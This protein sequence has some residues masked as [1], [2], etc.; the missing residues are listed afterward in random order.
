MFG[1]KNNLKKVPKEELVKRE[2]VLEAERVYRKGLATVKD[3]IA[4][5]AMKVTPSFV[6]VGDRYARTLFIYTY[7][8]FLQTS[9]FSP[10]VN[11]NHSMD[12][13]MF[14]YAVDT[15]LLLKKLRNKVGQ[16]QTSIMMNEEKGAVRDPVLDTA[17]HDVE[18]LRD[19]LQQG[20]EKLFRF[21]LYITVYGTTKKELDETTE[22]MESVL[23]TKLVYSKHAMMQMEEGFNSTLPLGN[24]GLNVETNLNTAPLSTTFPFVSNELTSNEG[25]LYGINR[26]NNSLILF[27]RFSMENANA[28]VFA[29]SGAGKSY[30][31]KLEILRSLMMG[32]NVIVI[33]PENEY[34]YLSDAVGGSYL[35]ISLNADNRINPFDLPTSKG[36]ETT[37]DVL[38]SATVAIIGLMNLMLGEL[39]P[40]EDSIMDTAITQTYAKKDI[41]SESDLSKVSVPTM[42]DLEEVLDSMEGGENLALRLQKYTQGTFAGVFNQESNIN[43]ENQFVVFSIRDLE[44][45]LRPIGMYVVLNYIWNVVRS[46]L[47]RRILVV[48]EAWWMMQYEDS[49][50][51]LFGLAKRA[52]KYYLGVT[53][54]SQDVAD[55]LHS[56]YGKAIVTNSSIQ[57]LLKQSPAAIDLIADTFHLTD[58]EKYLLL[59]SDVGEG[60][61]FAGLKHVAIKIVASYTEDQVITSDPRQL[62]EIEQAKKDFAESQEED[63]KS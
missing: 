42:Q 35:D 29:K 62:L 52:R 19:K 43:M 25:I 47:K 16:I 50:K 49:A 10:I 22:A 54:I 44:D 33:D 58:G 59:E 23:S 5:A 63:A 28:V 51:F 36:G 56:D 32:S 15:E 24:N 14:L 48:D 38:R 2:A 34:K 61:F 4:P 17:F 31:T 18:E 1:L 45:E 13:S 21:S 46:Q 12:I 39:S 9:W 27:D 30:A 3:L 40:E 57:L 8:R 7:P 26:H 20:T 55:F 11:M 60:I 37:S 41:T 6:Q 53:T